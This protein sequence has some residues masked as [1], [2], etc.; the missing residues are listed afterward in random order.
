MPEEAWRLRVRA[1]GTTLT[2][3]FMGMDG[4]GEDVQDLRTK[5]PPILQLKLHHL[6]APRSVEV[7][8]LL[9]PPCRWQLV[10]TDCL[11]RAG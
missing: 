10:N 7:T 2:M 6:D 8:S 9:T 11:A 3:A 5:K 1:A 4:T